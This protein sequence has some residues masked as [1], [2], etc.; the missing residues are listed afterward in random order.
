MKNLLLKNWDF[1]R[2]LRLLI[3]LGVGGYAAWAGDYFLAAL[4]GLFIIQAL[5]NLSCCGSGGCSVASQKK[6][7]YQ[8]VIKP[9]HPDASHK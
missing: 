5:F 1:V 4:G 2:T 6:T 7:L 3:G 8:D 9:Y